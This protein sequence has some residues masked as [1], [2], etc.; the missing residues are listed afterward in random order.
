MWLEDVQES[1]DDDVNAMEEEPSPMVVNAA[2]SGITTRPA[3][4]VNANNAEKK[5]QNTKNKGIDAKQPA[6]AAATSETKESALVNIWKGSKNT[7]R[8]PGKQPAKVAANSKSKESASANIQK[9]YNNIL[10]TIIHNK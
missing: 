3:Q 4:V 6:K 9:G 2:P 10:S 5:N 1:I 7:S 8:T